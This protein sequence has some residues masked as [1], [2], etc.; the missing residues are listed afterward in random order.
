MNV[1]ERKA[2]TNAYVCPQVELLQI[3]YEA[4]ITASPGA[5]AGGGGFEPGGGGEIGGGTTPSPMP[6]KPDYFDDEE[7]EF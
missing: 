2:K 7:E 3:E 5:G 6:G 4:M 1:T